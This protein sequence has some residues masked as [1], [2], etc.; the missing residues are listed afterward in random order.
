MFMKRSSGALC[1]KDDL[2]QR[3]G[4]GIN[5]N[6]NAENFIPDYSKS[7]ESYLTTI[8]YESFVI[9]IIL[10]EFLW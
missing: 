4:K 6:I 1:T 2:L 10:F 5:I 8:R 7:K 3:I 9:W